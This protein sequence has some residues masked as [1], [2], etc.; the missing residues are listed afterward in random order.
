MATKNQIGVRRNI[1]RYIVAGLIVACGSIIWIASETFSPKSSSEKPTLT[2]TN[3]YLLPIPKFSSKVML[4]EAMAWRRSLREYKKEPVTIE[5]LSML[6]WA[7]QGISEFNYGLRTVPSAGG[8]YPLSIYVS[9]GDEG[10]LVKEMEY[11][12]QGSY[13]YNCKD[14]SLTLIKTGD[15]RDS[16]TIASLKQDWVRTGA[17]SIIVLATYERTTKV[18]GER[19]QRYVYMEDGHVGQNVYL[20]ATALNLGAVVIGAFDDNK[21]KE[22]IGAE[23]TEQPLYV[24]PVSAPKEPYRI[25]EQ[26]LLE[27]YQKVRQSE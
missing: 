26:E 14:H 27:Y 21:V 12:P 25:T 11:L 6:L 3:K 18:Y 4:E 1:L 5:N 24:I 9:V 23:S 8:T 16:L 19:G 15:V 7:A 22:S 2:P 20:M 10:V 13:K 17:I